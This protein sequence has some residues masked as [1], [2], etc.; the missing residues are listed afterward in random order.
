M[1][2]EAVPAF[3]TRTWWYF[4]NGAVANCAIPLNARAMCAE[5]TS[6]KKIQDLV[7]CDADWTNNFSFASLHSGGGQFVLGDASVRF[8]S[9]S[10]EINVYRA[11][12][13]SMDGQKTDLE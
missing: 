5:A 4:F 13:S 8:I 6:G 9:D 7:A 3:C 2:G 12:G 10:I 11:L 1:V